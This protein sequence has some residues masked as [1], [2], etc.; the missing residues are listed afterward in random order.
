MGIFLLMA[1]SSQA[2]ACADGLVLGPVVAVDEAAVLPNTGACELGPNE[3]E[4]GK[5]PVI[6]TSDVGAS[7]SISVRIVLLASESSNRGEA[8]EAWLLGGGGE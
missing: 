1:A 8:E 2:C 6:G 4:P 5:R 7:G 3:A